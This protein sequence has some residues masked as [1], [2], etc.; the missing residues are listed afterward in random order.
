MIY[1]NNAFFIFK[2]GKDPALNRTGQRVF[3]LA[4]FEIKEGYDVPEDK[5]TLVKLLKKGIVIPFH[6]H[7]CLSCHQIPKVP[8][9][10]PSINHIFKYLL[11][12]YLYA[13][14]K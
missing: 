10:I 2:I 3:V 12:I 9:T 13:K 4:I 14:H 7:W 8:S 11:G 5:A 1:V 6:K